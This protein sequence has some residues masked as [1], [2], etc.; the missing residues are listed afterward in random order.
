MV[1][2]AVT[3]TATIERGRCP[4]QRQQPIDEASSHLH[5]QTETTVA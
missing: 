4:Q 3:P 2:I 5:A 1:D